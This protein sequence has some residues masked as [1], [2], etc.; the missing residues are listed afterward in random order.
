M[1]WRLMLGATALAALA[2]WISCRRFAHPVSPF[3]VYYVAWF[4]SLAL[5]GAGWIAYTPVRASTWMLIAVSLAAF[6]VGWWIP[7]LAWDSRNLGS[8]DDLRR[9]ISE[10]K[11]Y[12]AIR[13]CFVLGAIGLAVFLHSVQASLGLAAYIEAPHE[14]RQAMSAGGEV[15]EGI[16]PFNWLNVSNVVLASLY[17][18][19]LRGRK[20]RQV[21]IMLG[22]SLAAV[23]LMEDRTRFFYAT[24]WTGF[25]LSYSMKLQVR[26]I[27]A[28]LAIFSA[29]LLAQFIA[30]AA[31]LG[32]VAEN[33]PVLMDSAH[34]GNTMLALLPPYMY[35]TSSFPA[36]QAYLDQA[37]RA[38][39]GAMTFYPVFKLLN[40][41]D[42]TMEPPA[43][44]AEFVSIPF[45]ANTFTWLHQFYT[46]FGFAGVL[47]GPLL[48]GLLASA[49]YFHMLR[50][51]SFY[52]TY[53]T[54]L[55]CFCLSLSIMVNHLT[56]G[57][58]WFF[59][60]I[61]LAIA[62]YVRTPEKRLI[63]MEGEAV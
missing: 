35:A 7:Y 46:D 30:V 50:T 53:A 42:P 2:V 45:E 31:W 18:F 55:F 47:I 1:N 23:L 33:S 25:I 62:V 40:L 58:A 9:G 29:V 52:S 28:G 6:G 3:S 22:F 57:P 24:L 54:A 44:V 43:I 32:K 56:Q 14:I 63:A 41:V 59:L 11:L 17:L 60:A 4:S 26:K 61:G 16:K 27:L 20:R 15:S 39:H 48:A 12:L 10:E 34:A 21:W 13:V 38:T 8:I 5:Y 37:P 51:R 36:L 19:A 49:M